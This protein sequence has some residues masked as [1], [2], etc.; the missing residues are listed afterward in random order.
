VISDTHGSLAAWQKAMAGPLKDVDLIIHAGDVLYHGPRNPFPG[1]YGP[2][3][4]AEAINNSP[5][6]I[7]IARGNCDSEVDQVVLTPPLQSPY[8]FVQEGGLRILAT[9]GHNTPLDEQVILAQYYKAQIVISGHTHI[10]H[11]ERR[12]D[13]LLLNP[14]SLALPKQQSGK[15]TLAIIA[16]DLVRIVELDSQV[17]IYKE[18]IIGH[19]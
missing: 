1:R 8:L 18:R 16:G 14:G 15:A 2:A 7:L 6:P 5:I 10:P 4:L 19:S 11:L 13:I 17:E 3:D 12:D 9:H